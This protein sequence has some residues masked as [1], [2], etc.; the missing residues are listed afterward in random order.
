MNFI[1]F[2]DNRRNS[3]RPLTFMRPIADIR[4]GILTIRQKWE[5]YLGTTTSTLTE[6]YLITKF[7]I[8]KKPDNILINGAVCPTSDLLIAIMALK[9]NQALVRKDN[10]IAMRLT[11]EALQTGSESYSK[12]VEEV[13]TELD[14][15][16][17][18]NSWDI[19]TSNEKAINEDYQLLTKGRKSQLLSSTNQVVGDNIFIEEGARI[20][21]AMLNATTGPIYI[22]RDAEVM[23]GAMLRGPLALCEH[24]TVKMGA[25]IYGATTIGPHSKVGGEVVNSVIFGYTNKAHDGFLGNSVL[26]EWCNIG[27]DSNTSNLKNTYDNVRIWNY[28][29][30]T[31][32]DTGLQFCGLIMGDH[33][34][35]GINTMFNTGSVVGV[36]S[37][38][39]GSGFQRNFIPSFHW[40][41]T[42]GFTT[43]DLKRAVKVATAVF[44]RRNLEFSEIDKEIFETVFDLTYNFRQL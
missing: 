41:G 40:G 2:D 26:A 34:K 1:L 29:E 3:L 7:P 5:R 36:S 12:S 38:I 32:V 42:S 13:E 10:V 22:A 25:K 20:E 14:F 31:F 39:F 6:K 9:P 33:S 4:V 19:F 17:I 15:I 43:F 16:E 24:S 8:I 37:N 44:R 23:E 21:F 30:Q 18:V 27:A 28:T 11:E 35:C